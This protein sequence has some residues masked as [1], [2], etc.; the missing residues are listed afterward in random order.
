LVNGS[1][2]TNTVTV[3]NN[4]VLGGV[5]T[6]AGAVTLNGIISPGAN[7][8]GVGTLTTSGETW[9]GGGTYL[10]GLNNSTNQSG[11]DLLNVNGTINFQSGFP[12]GPPFT[13]QLVSLNTNNVPGM[14]AGFE[15][16]VTNVWTVATASGGFLNFNPAAFVVNTVN[17]SNAI[18]GKFS[19]STNNNSLVVIYTPAPL[20]APILNNT[21]S[22]GSGDFEL[23]FSGPANQAYEVVASTNVALQLTNW[24]V[25]TNGLFGTGTVNFTDRAATNQQEFYRIVSP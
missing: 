24:I 18:T 7:T 16:W 17:F 6:I 21:L 3:K 2:G 22:S 12:F 11:W 19:V 1:I 13:I 5:G 15:N 10:F 8:G 23:S 4:A 25:L 9:N 14:V 20:V